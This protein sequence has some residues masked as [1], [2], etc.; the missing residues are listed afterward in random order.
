M[1]EVLD[2][3]LY[4]K[5]AGNGTLGMELAVDGIACGACIARIEGAVKRLPG[6]TEAR[7]NYTNRRLHVS[8][9]DGATEPAQILQAL[10]DSGYH[11]HPFVP[12]RAEQA[13]AAEARRLTRC[14]AVAGFAAM[15]IMLLSV[16][17]WSGNVTDITPET[18]DFFHWA[19]ALIA[20]PAAAY[21]GRPFFTSAWRAIKSRALNMDVPI[22]L[23]VI[24]ALGMSVVETANHAEHAYF[25]SAIMLLFFLLIGRT[26]DHAMRRKTRAIAGNLAALKAE[27]AH[28]FAGD[29]LV[30]VPV[31]ALKAGDR[32]LV[33]PGERV[34]ADGIVLG[35]NSQID[36]S[37]ITGETARRKV[38]SGTT[39]YAG[40]MNYSGALT[41]KVTAAGGAALIDEIEKLLDKAAS[42]KSRAMRLAD[43]A[44][45]IYAPLVH[46]TAALTFAGWLA[47]GATVHDALV[48]AI[49]VLIITCPC[50]LA[51]AIPAVQV[52]ASGAL[53]RANV[54]LNTGDAIER[55]AEVDTVIFDKTGTL[56]LPEP[57]ATDVASL[58]PELLQM[59]ARLALS[60]RHPLAVA[61][62]REAQTRAPF[63]GAVEEPGQGVRALVDRVDARLGSAEFCGVVQPAAG[64]IGLSTIYFARGA[65]V[66]AIAISQTLR[67][68][69]VNV[70]KALARFGLDVRILSG[71]RDEAV[72]PIASA[73]G[74]AYWQGGLKPADKI[75]LIESLKANGRRVLMVGDGLNDAPALAAA[76]VSLSPISA[77]DVTQAQADAVFLGER[78]KPV[79]DAVAISR[80]ARGL[81]TENL[82]L[83]VIYNAIAVP[84]AIAG[85]V[86]PLIAALAMSGS[87]LLVTLNALRARR[88]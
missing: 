30:S 35:G 11:G 39:I 3:S 1:P 12:Q 47:A 50:A 43:R 37:L 22:S 69:A 59:A 27:T 42:A 64:E 41:L 29:E 7:L 45:R 79:L 60:S 62:A 77:A 17:V 82:W 67:P 23:G 2:L 46:A 13:E 18:R 80:R 19:S 63:D 38:A 9:T 70:V 36:E 61:L 55:L 26:L 65:R 49:A 88:A 8:W 85:A 6:V 72:A 10:E 53:F 32:L 52:V 15:N 48:T 84:I 66:I 31:A 58:D 71:D 51:L 28:R 81:M 83:A 4:A 40:S 74:I 5:P 78:L 34:P 87:S 54:I 57:R 16:S 33:K 75:A 44:S 24:L 68:D 73:L 25:D 76:H 86:T 56:T 20:L 14:L 21:A